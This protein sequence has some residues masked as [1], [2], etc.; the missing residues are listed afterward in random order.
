MVSLLR[1]SGGLASAGRTGK[2][3]ISVVACSNSARACL[4]SS[5]LVRKSR[6]APARTFDP[7]IIP[8]WASVEVGVTPACQLCAVIPGTVDG[9]FNEALGTTQVTSP[10]SLDEG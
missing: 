9:K 1:S 2:Y 7:A 8:L 6:I 5:G 10:L 3:F 4:T